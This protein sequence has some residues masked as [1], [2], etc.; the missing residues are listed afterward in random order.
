[1]A[2]TNRS[3]SQ[4][5]PA[6]NAAVAQPSLISTQQYFQQ[7]VMTI[8]APPVS[9]P[10]VLG[11]QNPNYDGPEDFLVLVIITTAVC[12]LLNLMSLVFGVIAIVM[13]AMAINKKGVYDYPSAQRYS[14]IGVVLSIC[15]IVWT[16]IT[17][18]A[19]IGSLTGVFCQSRYYY[20]YNYYY[21]GYTYS[22]YY[23][24]YYS[25]CG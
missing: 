4:P 22:N 20:D 17:S 23:S 11:M 2:S 15:T 12:A 19:I 6:Y 14:M 16:G 10:P 7:P 1:M 24:Y 9:T 13:A 3:G 25:L 5:P 8:P 18:M 21:Y